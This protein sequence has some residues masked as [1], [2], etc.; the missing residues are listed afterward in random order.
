MMAT[1]TMT[2]SVTMNLKPPN[3]LS[4][5]PH[6]HPTQRVRVNKWKC[7]RYLKNRAGLPNTSFDENIPD[8]TLRFQQKQA[9]FTWDDLTDMYPNRPLKPFTKKDKKG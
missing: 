6:P 1:M 4:R 3:P 7:V 5:V 8:L 2:F 9:N